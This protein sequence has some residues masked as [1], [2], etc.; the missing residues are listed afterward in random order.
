MK[1]A[2]LAVVCLAALLLLGALAQASSV[3]YLGADNM[4]QCPNR[5]PI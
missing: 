3:T 4:V 2:V 1:K 5:T